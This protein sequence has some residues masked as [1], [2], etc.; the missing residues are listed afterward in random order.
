MLPDLQMRY[1]QL[2]YYHRRIERRPILKICTGQL[3]IGKFNN[4]SHV[5]QTTDVYRM[6]YNFFITT[7][8]I[9]C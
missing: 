6:R 9:I 4:R 5:K 2:N 1:G 7:I 3:F 8:L